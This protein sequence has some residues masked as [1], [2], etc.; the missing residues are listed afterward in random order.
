MILLLA[1]VIVSVAIVLAVLASDRLVQDQME[2]VP[3]DVIIALITGIAVG[4]EIYQ[5]QLRLE[6]KRCSASGVVRQRM[7]D[8]SMPTISFLT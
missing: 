4:V 5:V 1:A 2:S 3:P 8:S 6:R 7:V